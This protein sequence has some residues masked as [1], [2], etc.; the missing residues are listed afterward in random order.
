MSS[1]FS[2][3]PVTAIAGCQSRDQ[4]FSDGVAAHQ[5]A[6]E[7]AG[8]K[9]ANYT[10]VDL[11]RLQGLVDHARAAGRDHVRLYSTI[12]VTPAD[13]EA[14]LDGRAVSADIREQLLGRELI[15]GADSAPTAG[16][17]APESTTTTSGGFNPSPPRND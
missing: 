11:N 10:A 4:T 8:Y 13:V 1:I 14:F 16:S 12:L 3:L 15:V 7:S 5:A 6:I 2:I 17:L 9:P